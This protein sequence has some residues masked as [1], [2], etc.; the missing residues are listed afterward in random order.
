MNLPIL[1]ILYKWNHTIYDLLFMAVF[2]Q[3]KVK[4]QSKEFN[5]AYLE[6]QFFQ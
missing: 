1:K 3:H 4:F 2:M 6:V 5:L